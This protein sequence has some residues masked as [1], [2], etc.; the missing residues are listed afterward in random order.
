MARTTDV[1][2]LTAL[3]AGSPWSWVLADLDS[4][5]SSLASFTDGRPAV[6]LH[7]LSSVPARR[8]RSVLWSPPLLL[9]HRSHQIRT[10]LLWPHWTLIN[11]LKIYLQIQS[12]WELALQCDFW[13]VP[14]SVHSVSQSYITLFHFFLTHSFI[15]RMY[16]LWMKRHGL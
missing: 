9:G 2:L 11:L 10:S 7:G 1:Y 12:H 15:E 6:S 16:W 5:R 14:N 3:E 13:L 8:E 4:G